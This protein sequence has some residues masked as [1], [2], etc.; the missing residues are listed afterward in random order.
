MVAAS[1]WSTTSASGGA[2]SSQRRS[3]A[4]A[5]GA[6]SCTSPPRSEAVML[7]R[8]MAVIGPPA[9]GKT[10]LTLGLAG[11]SGIEVF[12]LREHVPDTVLAA[13]A[14]SAERIGG[15]DDPTVTRS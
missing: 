1:S 7:E 12:R 15:I 13:T 5:C 2:G 4:S 3:A 6:R 9:V 8:V 10:T 14:T 11:Q